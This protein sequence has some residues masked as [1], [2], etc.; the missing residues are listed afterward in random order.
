MPA[1]VRCLVDVVRVVSVVPVGNGV[2][3]AC[4]AATTP[5]TDKALDAAVAGIAFGARLVALVSVAAP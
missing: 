2:T 3:G 4:F 1:A 5:T